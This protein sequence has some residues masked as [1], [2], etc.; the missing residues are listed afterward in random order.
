[1]HVQILKNIQYAKIDT[2]S[3]TYKIIQIYTYIHRLTNVFMFHHTSTYMPSPH[4]LL[5]QV[6]KC[7]FNYI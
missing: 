3:H 6:N 1:M 7:I 2:S 5:I 4:P